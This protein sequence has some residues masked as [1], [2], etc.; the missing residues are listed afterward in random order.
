M[1][2][3]ILFVL[4]LAM[5]ACIPCAAEAACGRWFPGKNLF[6]ARRANVEARQNARQANG[7]PQRPILYRATHPFGGRLR[8][9]N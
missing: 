5:L 1:K 2:Y 8:G 7:A 4:A 3:L 6:Q 9:C